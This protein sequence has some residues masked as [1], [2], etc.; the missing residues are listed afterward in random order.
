MAGATWASYAA[1]SAYDAENNTA[2]V[3][4]YVTLD[5]RSVLGDYTALDPEKRKTASEADETA[6][7]T[8]EGD[9]KKTALRT[10]AVFPLIMLVCYVI[11]ILY[12]RSRGG[13]KPV[14]LETEST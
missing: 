5:K 1:R 10:T 13:Y 6:I 14:E 9:A 8:V 12:F 7:A 4:Q 2:L 11:L 3:E